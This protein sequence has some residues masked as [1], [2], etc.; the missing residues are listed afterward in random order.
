MKRHCNARVASVMLSLAFTLLLAA[1]GGCGLPQMP[2]ASTSVARPVATA[3]P[4]LSAHKG[5]ASVQ[6]LAAPSP[7]ATQCSQ[8]AGFATA[9]AASAGSGFADVPFPP[10]SVGA[11]AATA[12][13]L[14]SFALVS[15]C[16]QGVG[17]QSILVFYA[18]RMVAAGWTQSATYPYGGDPT[19]VCGDTYCWRKADK[20]VRYVSLEQMS[21]SQA[22]T[23]Y[24]LRVATAPPPVATPPALRSASALGRPGALTTVSASCHAGEQMVGGGYDL[25]S[26]D[27]AYAVRSSYPS[28]AGTWTAS[29]AAAGSAN[30]ELQVYVV[31]VQAN[32]SLGIQMRSVPFDTSAGAPQIASA[33][34]VTGV[35]TGGGAQITGNGAALAESSPSDDG[36]SWNAVAAA[37]ANGA[38]GTAYALC[39]T[40]NVDGVPP[41]TDPFTLASGAGQQASL[42]CLTGQWLTSGGFSNADPS[43]DGKDVFALNAPTADNSR[44]FLDGYNLDATSAHGATLRVTCLQPDPQF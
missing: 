26:S 30:L 18:Q 32:Y 3:I 6:E 9:P 36:K 28:A 33:S 24:T 13:N 20:S 43:A 5:D 23:V 15:A 31:C 8:V 37:G 42:A 14:Y 29:A 39:A 4:P 21:S 1:L 7:S 17:P 12:A 19:H 11:V 41:L 44:W 35:V 38:K 40:L 16:A 27:Y 22:L 10:Q 34:C 25:S 2:G